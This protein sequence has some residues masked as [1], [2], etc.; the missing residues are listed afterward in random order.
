MLKHY[1]NIII[2]DN[3]TEL[4][5]KL[6]LSVFTLLDNGKDSYMLG[7]CKSE[8]NILVINS[9]LEYEIL[10][11]TNQYLFG[12][13]PYDQKEHFLPS[14]KSNNT[15]THGFENSKF[16]IADGVFIFKNESY[17]FFGT[18]TEYQ[19]VLEKLNRVNSTTS[20][21]HESNLNTVK[22]K[23][24][25]TKD[26]YIQ[27]VIDIKGYIQNGDI[28]EMNY[29]INV[30]SKN[31]LINPIKTYQKLKKKTLAPFSAYL[32]INNAT[33]LSASP[34]RFVNK[35]NQTLICQPIKGT[36]KR[37]QTPSEDLK[38]IQELGNDQKEIS[39]NVMIVDLVR[40]DLSKIATISSTTVLELCKIYSFKTVHQLI[41]TIQCKI[42][43]KTNFAHIL[44]ALFPMGSM[45]GAPK[46]NATR[47]IENYENFKRGI[48]SGSIGYIAPNSSYD[49]NVVIRSIVCNRS[50]NTLSISVGSAITINSS[51][52]HEYN[53]CLLKLDAIKSALYFKH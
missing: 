15:S 4:I 34:E 19:S 16:F 6:N 40:N 3:P 51:P 29:C 22:L 27:N 43:D 13:I 53:E 33:V 12:Y 1:F 10:N 7:Y 42:S 17:I 30:E 44:E 52:E 8:N 48:Y 2:P 24:R 28:Y 18:E 39:E 50:K 9:R 21:N 46:L 38:L 20:A 31:A 41:S 5:E 49:F 36:S 32:T 35:S 45:T 25:T 47:I 11:S 23:H 26:Q 14:S 37:G